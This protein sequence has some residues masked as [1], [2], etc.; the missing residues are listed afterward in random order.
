MNAAIS[1]G[2]ATGTIIDDDSGDISGLLARPINGTCVA[3][4][5]PI[6]NTSIATENPFPSLP[7]LSR[8]LGLMQAPGDNSQWYV[9]EKN[10]RVLRFDNSSSV[11]ALSTFIDISSP[12]DPIDVDS[13]G[14]ESGLLGMAFHPNYGSGNWFV[15]LSYTIDGAGTGGPF[16][17]VVSR[18]ESK[19]NG[20][21]LDATDAVTVLTLNQAGVNHNGGQLTFGPD[22]MLYISFGDGTGGAPNPAVEVNN[23]LGS[24][25]RIDVDSGLPYG[26]PTDNPFAGNALCNT[27]VGAAP[28]PEKFAWGFRNPWKWSFDDV[29]GVLWLGDVGEI[30]WEEINQVENGGNYGWRCREGA[31]DFNPG[32]SCPTNL[33]DPVIEYSHA[34]GASVTGGV[35]YRGTAIPELAGRYIFGDFVAGKIFASVDGGG[36]S[37]GF[38]TLLDTS[39]FIAA[40]AEE[41][42]GEILFLNYTGAGGHIQRI[43]QSGGSAS[44]TIPTQLS[45]TGC[46]DPSDP[47]LPASG[48]IPYDIN[49]PFW[50]DNAVKDRWYA[51]PDSATIDVGVDGD[52]QFPRGTVLM[53]NFRLSGALIETRLFM[54]H[55]DGVW[56]GYTY[57]WDDSGTDATRVIGGKTKTIGA[58]DW[59]YPNET[60]C[61][62]CHTQIAGDSLGLE[63]GQLNKNL[64]YPST[65]ITANQLVTAD[66]VDL[67]TAALPPGSPATLPNYPDPGNVSETLESRA[68]SYLHTNCAGCH[69]AD[70][71]TPSDIDLRY[72]TALQD[73]N[74]CDAPPSGDLGIPDAMIITPGDAAAS[75]LVARTN[76]RDSDAMPPLGSNLPDTVGVQLLTDWVNSLGAC[77]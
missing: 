75:T 72:S 9:V 63:H 10:G 50:S 17:S 12:T 6:V 41:A 21:T 77:P 45:A 59:I 36:G 31:H 22:G 64:M 46:V 37:F 20:L 27:G 11:S 73:T 34:V 32:S 1:D 55:P 24:I 71:P 23:L 61:L 26:I 54:R 44:D 3:P 42:N 19:D 7:P 76:R 38:E 40:F 58:Q 67:L 68:R 5:R 2:T 14:G 35:V 70:G 18:L 28:C 8:P 60:E 13:S 48:L 69:R 25:L 29:T 52:W 49:S 15:Y 66:A 47:T 74:T 56:G 51:I 57:E 4:E 30:S 33:I 53:K 65:G 39:F 62:L 16:V 43:I